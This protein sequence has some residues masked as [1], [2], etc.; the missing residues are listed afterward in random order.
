[1]IIIV[2]TVIEN[3]MEPHPIPR[4]ITTFEFK[5][6]GFMTLKQFLYLII[7]FPLAYIVLRIFPIPLINILLALIVAGAGVALAFIPINERPLDIWL[8]NLLKR[9]TSPTQYFY[10]KNNPPIY[11][12]QDLY[13]IADPHRVV[14]HIESQK[15]LTTY[16]TT[17]RLVRPVKNQKKQAIQDLI[18]KST[19]SLKEQLVSQ[20][21]TPVPPPIGLETKPILEK[22]KPVLTGIIKNNKK[23][24]IPGILIYIKDQNNN[25]IRLLKTN[26]HGIFATYNKLPKGEYFFEIKDPKNIYFFDRMKIRIEEEENRK[27]LEFFSKELI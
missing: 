3:L 4:Q 18:Q 8:K 17:N 7:F 2:I 9:L 21:P 6:I 14:S 23:I 5:L 26:P 16:L 24:P 12:L 11:F 1:M 22:K 27:P 19:T 25:P 15:K 13:F 10:Q 20:K